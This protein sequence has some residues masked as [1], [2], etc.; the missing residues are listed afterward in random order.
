[1]HVEVWGQGLT[2]LVDKVAHRQKHLLLGHSHNGP[3][4][5]V[6]AG[7]DDA[8]HVQVEVVCVG[9]CRVST[10]VGG[11]GDEDSCLVAERNF[12][13]AQTAPPSP[14]S[15]AYFLHGAESR[16]RGITPAYRW[17]MRLCAEGDSA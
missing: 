3:V 5:A 1:M 8:V 14:K 17:A 2:E 9:G 12:N 13:R 16:E 6:S 15:G 4:V 10:R 7:V 11:R